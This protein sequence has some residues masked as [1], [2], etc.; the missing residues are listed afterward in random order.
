MPAPWRCACRA[1]RATAWPRGRPPR[2]SGRRTRSEA[3]AGAAGGVMAR[4]VGRRPVVRATR[5]AWGPPVPAGRRGRMAGGRVR[6]RA[7]ARNPGLVA[8]EAAVLTTFTPESAA[9][10]P[11]P[12]WL[13]QRRSD[14]AATF[15]SSPLPS[16]KDEVWRYSRID[17]LDLDR[18]QPAAPVPL[19]SANVPGP[20]PSDRIH[21]LV[22]GLGPRSAL[23]VTINGVLATIGSIGGRRPPV[24]RSGHGARPGRGAARLGGQGP[25]RLPPPQ[26]GV[27][28]R[29]PRRGHRADG[30][31][32][33]TRWWS[34]T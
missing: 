13:R 28:H 17:R 30:R 5:R 27:R 26:R 4:S 33:R 20:S 1:G 11:G 25:R 7:E 18:F 32:S 6:W 8:R 23:V 16:E 12:A 29:S 2:W 3:M 24:R 10:Q 21:S 9:A 14:A 22:A 15:A 19:A 34:C 31:R